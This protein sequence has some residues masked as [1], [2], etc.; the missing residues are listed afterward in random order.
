MQNQRRGPWI[1]A[2]L[3]AEIFLLPAVWSAF[4]PHTWWGLGTVGVIGGITGFTFMVPF[5]QSFVAAGERAAERA[6]AR[7]IARAHAREIARREIAREDQMREAETR[8]KGL[9]DRLLT[10]EQRE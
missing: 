1:D 10:P 9:L 7:E 4:L 8:A 3:T 2:F 6:H 5:I